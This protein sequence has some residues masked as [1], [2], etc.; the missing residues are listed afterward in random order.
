MIS[1]L[2]LG[3]AG[4]GFAPMYAKDSGTES[5]ITS[6]L[7]EIAISP[8]KDR[9]GQQLRNALVQRITPRGEAGDPRFS[10]KVMVTEGFT[11]LGYRRD[12]FATLGSLTMSANIS[13]QGDGTSILS[14]T[15]TT[16]ANFDY[17]GP[18]YTSLATERD[19][20]ARAITQLA[21]EIRSQV[22]AAL[23]RYKANPNDPRFHKISAFKPIEPPPQAEES[24]GGVERR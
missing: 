1:I 9:L 16:V 13:L 18:R 5:G 19:A 21:D 10:L 4:C 17:L 11:D 8:I 20:E 6:D 24:G 7:A 12:S 14:N 22:A 15:V 2:V 3:P 23:T